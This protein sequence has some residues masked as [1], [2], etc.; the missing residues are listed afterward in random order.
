MTTP[1][2]PTT[3]M[4]IANKLV[5]LCS[6]GK[7]AEAVE[8]LLAEDVVSVEAMDPPGGNRETRGRDAVQAKGK[9]WMDNHEI[10]SAKVT[11]PWPHG[12]RFVV[13]FN[14]DVT[15]KPSGQRMVM[16]EVA[17]YTISGGKIVREEFFY[18]MQ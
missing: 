13:G 16:D 14:Y 17:L 5:E 18:N 4:E 10:H 6:V 11:G 3:T 2:V 15:F 7:N 9:W 12:D 1:N 8:L